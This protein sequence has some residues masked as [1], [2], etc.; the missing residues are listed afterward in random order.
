LHSIRTGDVFS[1]PYIHPLFVGYYFAHQNRVLVASTE[2]LICQ[3]DK[4]DLSQTVSEST[5]ELIYITINLKINSEFKLVSFYVHNLHDMLTLPTTEIKYNISDQSAYLPMNNNHFKLI[6][7]NMLL[8]SIE[9]SWG[10]VL[11]ENDR[12]MNGLIINQEMLKE[13]FLVFRSHY[14]FALPLSKVSKV[15]ISTP[16][17]IAPSNHSNFLG[18]LNLNGEQINIYSL[19]DRFDLQDSS[20]NDE[21]LLILSVD[22][23]KIGFPVSE[24]KTIIGKFHIKGLDVP[25]ILLKN[26]Y[27]KFNSQVLTEAVTIKL[28]SKSKDQVVLFLDP[29]SFV[30]DLLNKKTA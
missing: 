27:K 1:L 5:S 9:T 28:D 15:L 18:H 20:Q 30:E 24:L 14:L 7:I 26:F 8:E 13:Q 22:G 25:T 23:K 21:Y 3:Q 6:D 19:K 29:E 4:N 11:S 10:H 16:L 12:A 17:D 2:C